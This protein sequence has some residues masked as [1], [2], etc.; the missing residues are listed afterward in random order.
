MVLGVGLASLT[1][2]WG[3]ATSAA[4][5]ARPSDTGTGYQELDEA[6]K[7]ACKFLWDHEPNAQRFE[8]CGVLYRGADRGIRIGLPMTKRDPT[9]CWPDDP[10]GNVELLGRYHSHRLTA[11][12]SK[13]DRRIAQQFPMLGHY[14]CSPSG[15]VRRFSAKEGTVVV[16]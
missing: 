10:G 13:D 7:I 11:E 2:L 9:H 4:P 3:C 15:V 14:L 1:G 12:P 6:A 8:Y 16:R 5:S